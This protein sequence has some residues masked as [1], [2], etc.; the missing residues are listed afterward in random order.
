MVTYTYYDGYYG[1]TSPD[2]VHWTDLPHPQIR[3]DPGDVGNFVWDA[4]RSAYIG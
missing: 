2:G 3:E 1:S 4:R